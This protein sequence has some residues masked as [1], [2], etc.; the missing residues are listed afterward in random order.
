MDRLSIQ[1]HTV[2]NSLKFDFD[3]T[4]KSLADMGYDGVE[5]CGNYGGYSPVELQNRLDFYGLTAL[6][7]HI[8][9][10][11]I[12]DDEKFKYHTEILQKCGCIYIMN[13]WVELHSADEALRFGE[14]L[15]SAAE[16]CAKAGFLYGHHTH[17]G[18]LACKDE[19]GETYFDLMMSQSDLC[20]VEFDTFWLEHANANIEEYL[21]R[22]AGN[23]NLLH[24]KQ[25]KDKQ[26][27]AISSLDD[28]II[29]FS[30]VI[31]TAKKFGTEY[32]IYERDE[33][34]DEMLEAE[35]SIKF[36]CKGQAI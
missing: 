31:K 3:A 5:F 20:L 26:S 28:G 2:R 21:R 16:K 36:F 4:L 7:A 33:S 18:E 30:S 34:E 14:R 6:S 35:K 22:Y 15:Q 25:M 23:I 27:K 32:F 9:I 24:L 8:N 13:P 11:D 19:N 1:L 10:E 29:D 12:E 17:G